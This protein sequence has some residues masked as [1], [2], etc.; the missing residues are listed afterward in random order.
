MDTE[1]IDSFNLSGCYLTITP[2]L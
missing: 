1:L 2:D